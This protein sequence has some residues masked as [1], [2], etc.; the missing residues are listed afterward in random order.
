ME[1]QAQLGSDIALAFDE[2]PPTTPSASTRRV[3]RPYAPLARSAASSG[4]TRT[5]RPGRRSSGSSRAASTRTCAAS[6]RRGPDAAVDGIAIGGTL[7]RDKEQMRG[8]LEM[9][10]RAPD[11][12]PQAS[13]RD[14]RRMTWSRASRSASTPSTARPHPPRSPRHRPRPDLAALSLRPPQG[15][16]QDNRGRSPTA[17]LPRLPSPRPRLPQLPLPR[18][19]LTAVRLLCLHN[20]TY[21][22]DGRP[23][24]NRHRGRDSQLLRLSG[25]E[26]RRTLGRRTYEERGA[27]SSAAA[28][29]L[30]PRRAARTGAPWQAAGQPGPAGGRPRASPADA[31]LFSLLD[32]FLHFF[33]HLVHRVAGDFGGVGAGCLVG[34][35]GSRRRRSRRRSQSAARRPRPRMK[36]EKGSRRRSPGSGLACRHQAGAGAY[37]AQALG[38]AP[39]RGHRRH[40]GAAVRAGGDAGGGGARRAASGLLRGAGGRRRHA[41]EPILEGDGELGSASG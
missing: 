10:H 15:G 22:H 25:N 40:V 19:E 13:A 2:S 5:G 29:R 35:D 18:Q 28:G 20:L 26:G 27:P 23:R 3:D 16:G 37:T 41:L 4:T 33:D 14:R 17:A 24:P 39:G 7:G 36:R 34:G 21:M 8:V 31:A 38:D 32:Q 11:R 9:T 30:S 12:G 6:R 1:V